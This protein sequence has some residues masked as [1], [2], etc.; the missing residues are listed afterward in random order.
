LVLD[1]V[2]QLFQLAGLDEIGDVVVGVKR[3]RAA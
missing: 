3:L 2:E 1:L